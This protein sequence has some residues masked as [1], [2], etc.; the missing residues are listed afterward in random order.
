MNLKIIR[1]LLLLLFLATIFNAN[2]HALVYSS[3]SAADPGKFGIYPNCIA[4]AIP[5]EVHSWWDQ[6]LNQGLIDDAPR[7]LHMATCLPYARDMNNTLV[8]KLK[9]PEQFVVRIV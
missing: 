8:P 6:D 3:A 4:P 7:H 1:H 2:S 5:I 9:K